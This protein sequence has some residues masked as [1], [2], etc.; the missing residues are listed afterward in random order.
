MAPEVGLK[1]GHRAA[2]RLVQHRHGLALIEAR[3]SD[4]FNRCGVPD[5]DLFP[6]PGQG[7]GQAGKTRR[8]K[9]R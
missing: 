8:Q 4:A 6:N 7:C 5:R 2:L 9:R 3:L 1:D